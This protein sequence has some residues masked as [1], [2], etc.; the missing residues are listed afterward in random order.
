MSTLIL[1]SSLLAVF[2]A[3]AWAK[4]FRLRRSL[5]NLLARIFP[6]WRNAHET[7]SPNPPYDA[8]PAAVDPNTDNGL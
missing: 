6:H 1:A 8:E 2:L 3:L 4:E 7:D 5:Q